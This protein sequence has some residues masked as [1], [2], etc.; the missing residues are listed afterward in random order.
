MPANH[1]ETA[2]IVPSTV[3]ADYLAD[4]LH[5]LEVTP[6]LLQQ[7][8]L[9]AYPEAE[10]L[11]P[12]RAGCPDDPALPGYR[13]FELTPEAAAAWER[14][15]AA[16]LEDGIALT[17]LS[18][19]RSVAR[20]CELIERKLAAGMAAAGILNRLAPP[21]YSEHH[22]GR[23]LDLGCNDGPVLCADFADTPAFAWLTQ[24]AGRFAYVLSYPP[25]NPHGYQY[26]PWHWCYQPATPDT[27]SHAEPL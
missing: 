21:G 14:M 9:L 22:T 19:Y 15:H 8:G 2:A 26:E 12:L 3:A 20:Q 5:R 13:R 24:H 4:L 23:A 11:T 10:Q 16:A 18:A 7:R 6:A 25:G 17:V 1:H 27:P